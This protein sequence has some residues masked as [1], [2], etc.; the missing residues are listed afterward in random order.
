MEIELTNAG[1]PQ[2]TETNS[3]RQ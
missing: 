1:T 3:R 2:L